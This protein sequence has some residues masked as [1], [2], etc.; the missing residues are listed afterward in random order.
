MPLKLG[1]KVAGGD[2]VYG[3]I[4][5]LNGR[6]NLGIIQRTVTAGVKVELTIEPSG[7]HSES[8]VGPPFEKLPIG[9]IESSTVE[10]GGKGVLHRLYPTSPSGPPVTFRHVD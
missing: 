4:P 7:K 8:S 2:F 5:H 6:V 3:E 10:L 9:D 1:V